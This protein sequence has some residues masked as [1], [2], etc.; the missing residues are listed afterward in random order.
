MKVIDESG[1]NDS[2]SFSEDLDGL[3]KL[4]QKRVRETKVHTREFATME[5]EELETLLS[6]MKETPLEI[7]IDTVHKQ[8]VYKLDLSNVVSQIKCL[9]SN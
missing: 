4:F 9:N 1:I 5:E 6:K 7:D 2:L 8:S 3:N